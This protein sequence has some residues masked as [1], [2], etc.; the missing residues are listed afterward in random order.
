MKQLLYFQTKMKNVEEKGDVVIVSG[1][2]STG[3]IDRGNDR[4]LPE[5]FKETISDRGEKSP[6]PMLLQH[7][8]DKIIG[9]WPMLG[10]DEKG[11]IA[12]GELKYDIDDCKKKVK[13]GDLRGLSIGYRVLE[14]EVEDGKGNVIYNSE[15]GLVPGHDVDEMWTNDSIR[16]IKKIDLVE[17]SIVSTPM[18][19][20]AFINSV[21][22]FFAT[23]KKD[24]LA[25]LK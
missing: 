6:I 8:G 15:T 19:P 21:K 16:V 4:V 1:Y 23:E 9:N 12:Q 11:L 22:D 20:Y 3:D 24:L 10:I 2:A 7:D 14:Y 13:N 17:I 5:A 18:N 25:S